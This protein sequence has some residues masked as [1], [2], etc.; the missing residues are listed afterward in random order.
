MVEAAFK[1]YTVCLFTVSET[2]DANIQWGNCWAAASRR[3]SWRRRRSPSGG[4]VDD[5]G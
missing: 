1:Q 4:N 3:S 5:G 2:F